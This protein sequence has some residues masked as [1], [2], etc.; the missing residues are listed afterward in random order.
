MSRQSQPALG[1]ALALGI[2]ALGSAC[3]TDEV[4]VTLSAPATV[5]TG[6]AL[7]LTLIGG[8]GRRETRTLFID[9]FPSTVTLTVET[10]TEP[11]RVEASLFR[12][13]PDPALPDDEQAPPLE[14]RTV[15]L[16][17]ALGTAE[18][19][20]GASAQ[21]RLAP[22]DFVLNSR[23]QGD[24]R[25]GDQLIA[26]RQLAVADDGSFLGAWN[27]LR[28]RDIRARLFNPRGAAAANA[29]E[30]SDRDFRLDSPDDAF[31]PAVVYGP[32]GFLV[33]WEQRFGPGQET[34]LETRLLAT[35]DAAVAAEAAVTDGASFDELPA[36][37]ARDD[38]SFAI[39]WL[40][41][42]FGS[43]GDA[44]FAFGDIW[45]R[46]LD[47]EGAPSGEEI[48]LTEPD[49]LESMAPDIAALDGGRVI[50]TWTEF[51]GDGQ[52][53]QGAARVVDA[54]G[55]ADA[56]V[57]LFE[58]TDVES[59]PRVAAAPG[60]DLVAAAALVGVEGAQDL[61][62]RT[63]SPAAID[64]PTASITVAAVAGD[65]LAGV[66]FD[67]AVRPNDGVIALA[68]STEGAA[69]GDFD[70]FWQ[71]F[72]SD[73][74]AL[75][76][77]TRV[78]TTTAGRQVN[79]TVAVHTDGGFLVGWTDESGAAPD[80]DGTAVRARFVYPPEAN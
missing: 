52:Q 21:L 56:K 64:A 74:Q 12:S 39:A 9:R 59:Q 29:F 27:S 32:Q 4:A 38:G 45:V 30:L 70:V 71:L 3:A 43:A 55:N 17:L 80:R 65:T 25:L 1:L 8:D 54:E 16:L 72:S 69:E 57:V 41:A 37:A 61:A 40:R 26:G 73:L 5:P 53:T 66:G 62:L 77:P 42:P 31:H 24:Q 34:R 79:P 33:A 60:Q 78:N 19:E 7:R 20:V 46:L 47:S 18:L 44:T 15:E 58:P 35:G 63:Y 6:D 22:A 50:V 51:V 68:W 11:L 10:W 48:A 49:L 13:V 76:P 28:L 2:A 36:V 67:V 23:V 14:P 75:S